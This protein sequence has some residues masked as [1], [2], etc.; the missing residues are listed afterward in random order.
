MIESGEKKEEYRELKIYWLKRLLNV[1]TMEIN[2]MKRQGNIKQYDAIE[3]VNGYL[4]T[5][6]RFLIECKGL[7]I[8]Y[9][10]EKWGAEPHKEYFI[11]KLGEILKASVQKDSSNG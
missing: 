5:S 7:E 4:P 10:K 8:D 9:G 11:I 2:Q 3:F 6:P 1:P